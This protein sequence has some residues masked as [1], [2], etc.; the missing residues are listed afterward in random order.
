M[1]DFKGAG[2]MRTQTG[3]SLSLWHVQVLE[4]FPA[5]AEDQGRLTTLEPRLHFPMLLLTLMTSTGR[6]SVAGRRSSTLAD[7][8]V[9]G[10]TVVGQAGENGRASRLD[11]E[12]GEQRNERRRRPLRFYRCSAAPCR[13]YRGYSWRHW[14]LCEVGGGLLLCFGC[15]IK[16]IGISFSKAPDGSRRSF[17]VA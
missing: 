5:M 10:A 14:L 1:V 11:R 4:A 17:V 9:V 2:A 8:F 12:R 6:L 16:I 15:S 3:R 13:L 7:P